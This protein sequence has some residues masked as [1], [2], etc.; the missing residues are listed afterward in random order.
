MSLSSEKYLLTKSLWDV[1]RTAH[2]TLR[3]YIQLRTEIWR[4]LHTCMCICA[5]FLYVWGTPY[6]AGMHTAQDGD[7]E[8]CVYIFIRVY[9][10]YLCM[11]EVHH[12]LLVCIQLRTEIWRHLHSVYVFMCIILYVRVGG[13]HYINRGYARQVSTGIWRYVCVCVCMCMR[14]CI[15]CEER[16]RYL[17][18]L[19]FDEM[20][21]FTS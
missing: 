18:C 19:R 12:T 6:L 10:H 11:F 17:A 21:L 8:V 16:A 9:V 5:L 3:V 20:H 4:Y 7:L 13:G 1:V 15:S 14:A 2:H